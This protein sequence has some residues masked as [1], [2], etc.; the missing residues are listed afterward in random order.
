MRLATRRLFVDVDAIFVVLCC[1]VHGGFSALV[2]LGPNASKHL[3]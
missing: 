3:L 1:L 2:R